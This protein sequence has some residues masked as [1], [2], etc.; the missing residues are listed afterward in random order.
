MK[1]TVAS[2]VRVSMV[3]DRDQ[4]TMLSPDDQ[5]RQIERLIDN[6]GHDR[7]PVFEDIDVS[8]R[9]MD[10]PD[11]RRMIQWVEDDPG[12]RGIAV[13]NVSRFAR[14]MSEGVAEIGRLRDLGAAV[15]MAQGFMTE[16]MASSDQGFLME[17]FNFLLADFES[18][19]IGSTWRRVHDMRIESGRFLGKPPAGYL[20]DAQ[21]G[22]VIDP[23]KGPVMRDA[24]ES[25][26]RGEKITRIA[27]RVS[28]AIGTTSA[29]TLKRRF[30]SAAYNGQMTWGGEVHPAVHEA[31]E[32]G[33]R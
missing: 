20:S 7:G 27:A 11:Y 9:S 32:L 12:H 10:R 25:Y 31:L 16:E 23:D 8:G 24:F 4:E 13:L 26:A 5:K 6:E 19:R 2:Y 22:L 15:L 3:G 18:R 29:R 14:N 30:V 21:V 1:R 33:P 28:A 17:G